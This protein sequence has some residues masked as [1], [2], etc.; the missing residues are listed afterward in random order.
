MKYEAEKRILVVCEWGDA[1]LV[2]SER[3]SRITEIIPSE[4][5]VASVLTVFIGNE[6][7]WV[8][9]CLWEVGRN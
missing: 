9:V 6:L 4:E 2:N 5:L 3:E 8:D 7:L 1:E